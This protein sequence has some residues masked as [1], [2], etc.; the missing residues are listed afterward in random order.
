M[1]G[2]HKVDESII[3][4]DP[5]WYSTFPS[6]C[7]T[8]SGELLCAFRRAPN[9]IHEAGGQHHVHP[10]SQCVLVRSSDEGQTWSREPAAIWP[11]SMGGQNDPCLA[12]LSDGTI[13]AGWFEMQLLPSNYGDAVGATEQTRTGWHHRTLGMWMSRSGD[14]GNSWSSPVTPTPPSFFYSDV[15]GAA[16]TGSAR[17]KTVELSDGTL[18]WPAYGAIRKGVPDCAICYRSEDAGRSWQYLSIIVRDENERIAY[19][20]PFVVETPSGRLVCLH[21]TAGL[22][23]HLATNHSTD[24]GKTWSE[25]KV[26]EVQGNP[27]FALPLAA[28]GMVVIT[29]RGGVRAYLLD[30]ELEDW[31]EAAKHPLW[32]HTLEEAG[33]GDVGYPWALLKSDNTVL[34]AYYYS[35]GNWGVRHIRSVVLE[36]R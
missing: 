4:H 2:L 19:H 13:L 28:G 1:A 18:L 33:T 7:R 30:D 17:T 32:L 8:G 10:N 24:G 36:V 31:P 12:T 16:R 14:G 26:R 9:L 15:P 21:R 5:A 34:A 23:A 25:I 35:E 6:L 11:S 22:D 29:A 20:E 27:Y 3:Y